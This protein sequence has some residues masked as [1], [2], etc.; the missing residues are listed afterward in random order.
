MSLDDGVVGGLE[1]KVNEQA[2][3]IAK[4]E[5]AARGWVLLKDAPLFT[6]GHLWSPDKPDRTWI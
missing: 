4:L 5:A 2:A 3:R 1:A 6:L